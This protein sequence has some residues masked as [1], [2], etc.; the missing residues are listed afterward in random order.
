MNRFE[1]YN[2]YPTARNRLAKCI[3]ILAVVMDEEELMKLSPQQVE[4]IVFRMLLSN[5]SIVEK[6]FKAK[7]IKYDKQCK[8]VELKS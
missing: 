6:Y 3:R 8:R 4:D 1:Y 5:D 7:N 2:R